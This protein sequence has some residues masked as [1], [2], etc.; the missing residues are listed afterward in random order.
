[1]ALW[2][3]LTTAD[4][5]PVDVNIDQVAYVQQLP[6]GTYTELVFA[7]AKGDNGLTLSVKETPEAIRSM[8]MLA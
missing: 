1:M 7:G 5:R 8:N 6:A 4:G 3:R 2:K